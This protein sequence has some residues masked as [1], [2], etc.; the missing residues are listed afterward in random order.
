MH[1]GMRRTALLLGI[2]GA[3][4]AAGCKETSSPEIVRVTGTIR[5]DT[6]E[7][8]VWAVRGDD[9]TTYEPLGGLPADFRRDG[10]RVRLEAK[11]RPDVASVHMVGPV[12][13]IVSIRPL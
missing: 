4:T 2:L 10:L 7:G 8:G 13:E 11:L 12:V 6:L 9:G 1:A 3:L 5:Y